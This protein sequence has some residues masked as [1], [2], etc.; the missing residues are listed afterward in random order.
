MKKVFISFSGLLLS[1]SVAF[2]QADSLR[3]ID[4]Q[5]VQ[6]VSTRASSQTPMTFSTVTKSDLQQQNAGQDI[7]FLLSLTPSVVATSD[8]GNGVGYTGIRIRGT[9]ANRINVTANGVPINDSESHGV[10]WVNMPDFASSLQDIQIQRGVGTST[11][12]AAAFGGSLNMKTENLAIVPYAELHGSYGAFNTSKLTVKAGSGLLRDRWAFDARLSTIK[13]DGFIDRASTDLSSY[14]VQG[15][16]FG[17]QTVIKLLSFGGKEQTYHAWDGVPK[18]KLQSDRTY[19]PSGYMG[20]DVFG[21][22]MYYDNQTDNYQQ[23]HYHLL[24]NHSF[25]SSLSLNMALHYTKGKGYYEEYK[26]DRKLK[27]YGLS[28]FVFESETIT[29]SD[30]VRQ[31]H[32]DNDFG[33]AVFS[34]DY[35]MDKLSVSW[36]GGANYYTGDHFGK[37]TWIKNYAGDAAFMPGKEYYT[38]VGEKTDA[39]TYLKATYAVTNS[40]NLYG[41]VQYRY[42]NYQTYGTSDRWDWM[43]NQM[44]VLDINEDF[45][46]FNPKA[47][48]FYTFDT[49]SSAYASVAVGHREPTRNNYKDAELTANPTFERLINYE[50]GY[51][52]KQKN[53]AFGAN[54]YYMDYKNQLVLTGKVNE[55]GEALTSNTPESYRVGI[56]LTA[57]VHITPWLQWNGN[58]TISENIIKNYTEYVDLY[59]ENWDWSSQVATSLGDTPI[60]FSPNVIANS[61]FSINHNGWSAAFQSSY[62]GK[63][64]IDNSGNDERSLSAYFVNNA[65]LGY[66]FTL[67]GLKELGI[68]ILCNNILNEQYESNAWVYSFYQQPDMNN[69]HTDR[70]ADFGYFP[71]AGR[72][73]MLNMVLKF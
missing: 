41:D 61:V 3:L 33:G 9:D 23:T 56:E 26:T 52:Y 16:Y 17:K 60:S 65:R 30:L 40:L 8:A 53:Y 31:K 27:E 5:E 29:K 51:A 1:A 18:D 37:I 70:Y 19:N 57:G 36:G 46:F 44:Q 47:G 48:V 71:Q 39:N 15:G 13:S 28:S 42:I 35:A 73:L 22:P 24:L 34:L 21:N 25:S 45:H 12:G 68:G 6:V 14:F 66:T 2:G 49:Y 32:L 59:D 20:D 4:L 58:L 63:Q 72:N 62:V 11:N 55:I 64:Y 69:P 54:A 67:K 43:N 7:P 50:L 10:F 38:S